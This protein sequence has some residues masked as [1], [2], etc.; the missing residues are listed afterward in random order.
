MSKCIIPR[1]RVVKPET[2]SVVVRINASEYARIAELSHESGWSM[3]RVTS[4]LLAYALED[5]E[6]VDPNMGSRP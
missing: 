5:V 1:R 4:H 3:Q 2:G 6:L